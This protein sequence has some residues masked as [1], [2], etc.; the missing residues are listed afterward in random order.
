MAAKYSVVV[1][2]TILKRGIRGD[3]L[4]RNSFYLLP[5]CVIHFFLPKMPTTLKLALPALEVVEG[6]LRYSWHDLPS[7]FQDVFNL[8]LD[9]ITKTSQLFQTQ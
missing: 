5:I 4:G 3:N 6:K 1:F 9:L 7:I 2:I 8:R